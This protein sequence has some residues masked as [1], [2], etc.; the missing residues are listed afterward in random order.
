MVD[1]E[2]DLQII[3][4]KWWRKKCMERAEWKRIT[5]KATPHMWL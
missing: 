3:G 2:E 4:I 5:D 1:I